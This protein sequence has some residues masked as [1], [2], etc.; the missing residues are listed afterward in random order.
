MNSRNSGVALWIRQNIGIALLVSMFV[1]SLLLNVKL[2]LNLRPSARP[3][4][5]VV[6]NSDLRSIQVEDVAGNHQ[7]LKLGDGK[8]TVLYIMAPTCP[9]CAKNIENIRALANAAGSEYRFLGVSNTPKGL[10]DHLEAK[11]L[12]FPVYAV[13]MDHLPKGFDPGPTP[14]T[15]LVGADGRV[16]KV[17]RGAL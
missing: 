4:P 17:W 8:P 14:Q 2:G 9:W 5:G 12:P 1:G 13:D 10:A 3:L 16:E 11:P 15:V 7:A 6:L